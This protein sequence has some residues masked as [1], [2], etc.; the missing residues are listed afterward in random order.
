MI[1][2]S[3]HR[4]PKRID[5]AAIVEEVHVVALLT[6][7]QLCPDLSARIL[8][9]REDLVGKRPRDRGI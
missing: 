4:K 1:E 2:R 6:T 5:T 3:N 7:S 9:A 8:D